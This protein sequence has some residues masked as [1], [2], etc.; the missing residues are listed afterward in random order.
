[1]RLQTDAAAA[2]VHL[3]VRPA[4]HGALSQPPSALL[5]GRSGNG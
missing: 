2:P 3:G 1:V 4:G 5:P